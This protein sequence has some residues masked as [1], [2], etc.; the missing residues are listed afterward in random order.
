MGMTSKTRKAFVGETD[1]LVEEQGDGTH[2]PVVKLDSTSG[3][4]EDAGFVVDA[5]GN[6][7]SETQVNVA[8]GGMRSRNWSYTTLPTGDVEATPGAWT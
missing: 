1:P 2:I 7:K 5:S 3:E 4:W 8:T 6:L